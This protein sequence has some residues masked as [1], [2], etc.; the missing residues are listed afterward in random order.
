MIK[1]Y[2]EIHNLCENDLG[3]ECNKEMVKNRLTVLNHNQECVFVAVIEDKVVGFIHAETYEVLY[4]PTLANIL[5]I[6]VSKDCRRQGIGKKILSADEEWSKGE[7]C[8]D[9]VKLWWYKK[10]CSYVLS[11]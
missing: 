6:A 8:L 2:E 5:G 9:E 7:K 4:S 11:E 1:D 10:R 3:Y